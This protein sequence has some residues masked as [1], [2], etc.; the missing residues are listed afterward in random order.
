MANE[1]TQT[2]TLQAAATTA[3]RQRRFVAQGSGGAAEAADGV[4]TAGVSFGSTTA[5]AGDPRAFAAVTN[6]GCRV[7]VEA[8]EAV[9][10]GDDVASDAQGRAKTSATGD[11]IQ[12]SALTA[13]SAAG[14]IVDI[15]YYG[16]GAGR[17]T[18]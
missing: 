5:N 3:I 18:A 14:E 12:G 7:E 13:A 15:L 10:I 17:A 8:G 16:A 6:T 9:A 4:D 1:N 2:I 11:F